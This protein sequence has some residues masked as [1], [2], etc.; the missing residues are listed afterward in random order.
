M[1]HIVFCKFGNLLYQEYKRH[2]IFATGSVFEYLYAL[3]RVVHTHILTTIDCK[4]LHT[5]TS[6]C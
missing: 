6:K 5:L 4:S 2:Q 3:I 1:G